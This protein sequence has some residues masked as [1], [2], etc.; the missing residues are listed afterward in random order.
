MKFNEH[1][2][3]I[4]SL[5]ERATTLVNYIPWFLNDLGFV[6]ISLFGG[7]MK[8]YVS[9]LALLGLLMINRTFK[10][11]IVCYGCCYRAIAGRLIANKKIIN[12]IF[13]VSRALLH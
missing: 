13:S 12:K 2:E 8:S 5:Q 7:R 6:L 4:K 11:M 10:E 9:Y 3:K 1:S